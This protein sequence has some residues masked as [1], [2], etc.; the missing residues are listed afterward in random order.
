MIITISGI[1]GSGK[2]TAG[3]LLADRLGYMFYSMGDLRGRM[4]M[5]RGMTID[6]LNKLGEQEEWTDKDVDEYQKGL[7]QK[8]DNFIVDGWISWHFIP[9]S[10]KVLLQVDPEVGASRVFQH[11]RPDE[12]KKATLPALKRMLDKRVEESALRY[13]KYYGMEDAF[14]PKHFDLVIDTTKIDAETVAK[15]V[16]EGLQKWRK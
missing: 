3:R 5:E 16:S 7:G 8:E 4:A 11:Q 9:H 15:R 1:P 10:F 13:K 6:E 12:E 14:N 2:T